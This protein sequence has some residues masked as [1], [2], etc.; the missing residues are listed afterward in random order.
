MHIGTKIKDILIEKKISV[1]EFAVL[2][3]VSQDFINVILRSP[4]LHPELIRSISLALEHDL[5]QYY[6]TSESINEG[7]INPKV[8]ALK[9]KIADIEGQDGF[10]HQVGKLIREKV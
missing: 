8:K 1:Q 2:L 3:D 5:Y 9:E 6:Y 7:E 10:G 4:L